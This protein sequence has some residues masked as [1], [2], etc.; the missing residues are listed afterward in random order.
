MKHIFD[1]THNLRSF[2][3]AEIAQAHDVSLGAAH[4]F[5]DLAADLGLMQLNSRL[6]LLTLNRQDEEFR[7]A[8]KRRQDSLRLLAPDGI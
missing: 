4:S 3:V 1:T 6:T 5:I 7:V 8:F 2:L